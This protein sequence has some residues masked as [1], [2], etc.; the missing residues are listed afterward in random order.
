MDSETEAIEYA[1][2]HKIEI[3]RRLTD[4]NRYPPSVMPVTVLMAGSP[5]AGKTEF[6]KNLIEIVAEDPEHPPVRID[7]DELRSEIPN[8]TGKNS[9]QVQGAVSIL[10]GELYER[11]LKNKQTVI[12][13]GTLAAY[14]KAKENIDRSL[15]RGRRVIIFYVYQRP[16][17]AWQFTLAREKIEGRNIPKDV[18]VDRFLKARATVT[19]LRTEYG[20]E[21]IIYLVKKNF[22]TNNVESVERIP[23]D[24]P[25][26]DAYLT[27]T[28]TEESLLALL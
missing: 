16:E 28:Y 12:V 23:A 26:L 4:P 18:F 22:L 24:G 5:G 20:R 11:T 7:G 3:S 10:L 1:K 15:K 8:Y 13:D 25:G 21:V 14:D 27:D 6:S 19:Q 2:K 9:S 17:V